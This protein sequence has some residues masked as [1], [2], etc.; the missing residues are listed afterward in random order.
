MGSSSSS[1]CDP[2]P[3]QRTRLRSNEGSGVAACSVVWWKGMGRLSS[4]TRFRR[5]M[6]APRQDELTKVIRRNFD[7]QF[8]VHEIT[9]WAKGQLQSS[10]A[11]KVVIGTENLGQLLY[12]LYFLSLRISWA[13]LPVTEGSH[14]KTVF[15][16][17]FTSTHTIQQQA[18]GVQHYF[19]A[20]CGKN[21]SNFT[22]GFKSTKLEEAF[23]ISHWLAN[24]F[25]AAGLS[26][27]LDDD[28]LIEGQEWLSW[29]STKICLPVFLEWLGQ[30]R[31]PPWGQFVEQPGS[32]ISLQINVTQKALAPA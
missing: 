24:K 1:V 6:Q 26:L 27:S 28:R 13:S 10:M 2:G 32:K 11:T 8:L 4:I 12:N 25:C 29:L 18:L 21:I 9:W 7:R 22:G 23:I 17:R 14:N 30:P 20:R 15:A 3:C 16:I 31:R 5:G 19:V